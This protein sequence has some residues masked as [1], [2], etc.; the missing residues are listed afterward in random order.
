MR[1]SAL[2][3]AALSSYSAR[4]EMK[5][6]FNHDK[7]LCLPSVCARYR[8]GIDASYSFGSR[9]WMFLYEPSSDSSFE[10]NLSFSFPY[11]PINPSES[12]RLSGEPVLITACS[13]AGDSEMEGRLLNAT[14]GASYTWD[15]MEITVATANPFNAVSVFKPSS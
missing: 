12:E 3:L 8:L 7:V 14:T 6:L 13:T 1:S 11:F 9:K 2:L 5:F 10:S 15:R 4:N